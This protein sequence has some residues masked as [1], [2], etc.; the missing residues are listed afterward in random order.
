MTEIKIEKV[1]KEY[2]RDGKKEKYYRYQITDG[3]GN[4][5]YVKPLDIT[6]REVL[7]EIV[8]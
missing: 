2:E 7:E 6:S 1:E 5:C 4:K 8:K 3:H